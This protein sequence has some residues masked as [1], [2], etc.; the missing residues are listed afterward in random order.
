MVLTTSDRFV[1]FTDVGSVNFG[2]NTNPY[3]FTLLGSDVYVTLLGNLQTARQMLGE[4]LS[5]LTQPTQIDDP[6]HTGP[7]RR[8]HEIPR[9]LPVPPLET[10][11]APGHGMNQVVGA[12]HFGHDRCK[13][14]VVQAISLHDFGIGSDP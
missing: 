1:I 11:P 9:R 5:S 7:F 12:V 14:C 6:P 4:I 8:R 2:A 10:G 13:R 3:G